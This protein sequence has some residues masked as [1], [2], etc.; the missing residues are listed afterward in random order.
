MTCAAFKLIDFTSLI[1]GS[2]HSYQTSTDNVRNE[3]DFH[4]GLIHKCSYGA[5][6]KPRNTITHLQEHISKIGGELSY[7]FILMYV[8]LV[9]CHFRLLSAHLMPICL[10]SI[11][12]RTSTPHLNNYFRLVRRKINQF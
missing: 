2:F 3:F 4:S 5:L 6:V 1:L 7:C 8:Y 11:M 10:E 9:S 12:V